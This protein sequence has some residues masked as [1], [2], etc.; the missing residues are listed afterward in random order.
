MKHPPCARLPLVVD[1]QTAA[2]VSAARRHVLACGLGLGA[3]AL[4]WAPGVARAQAW[5]NKPLKITTAA[6]VGSGPD[7]SLR[8]I[9]DQLARRWSQP[10]VVD[11][12]PGG[13][14]V[15]AFNAT[16]GAVADGHELIHLDSTMLTS[17]V[18]LYGKLP[19]D[20]QRDFEPIRPTLQTDFF[21]VV[22]VDSPFK[23]IDD[24]VQAAQ[25]APGKL[26]YGSWGA[27]APGTWG[28]CGCWPPPA[29][30]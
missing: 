16:R 27:A 17:N 24:I 11:N 29:R 9:A 2:R 3:G 22:A 15:V 1:P 13:N 20:P 30:R 4:A 28:R 26:T 5:P 23:S 25:A 18:H 10:V 21:V 12:R 19:Y 6:S 8:L 14:G 7:V